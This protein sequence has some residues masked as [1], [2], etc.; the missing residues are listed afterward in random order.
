MK[1]DAILSDYDGTLCPTT[2][3]TLNNSLPEDLLNI[4][5][6][7]SQSIP[8]CIVSSKDFTFLE[9][10]S[11]F[12]VIICSIMGI[13]TFFLQKNK[14][15][16]NNSLV[17]YETISYPIDLKDKSKSNS[18]ARYR[19]K[20]KEKLIQ[21]SSILE[22]LSS[23]I[24]Q[25]FQDIKILKKYTHKE[26]LL[27][28]VS[29][30]YR[31]LLKWESYKINIEP[32][33]VDKISEYIKINLPQNNKLYIQEYLAHPFLD[34]YSIYCNK[35]DIVNEIRALLNLDRTKNILYLGDSEND[36]SAFRNAD[37]SINIK[38]DERLNTKLDS[39]Y[40]L[41]FNQLSYFLIKL[42]KENFNFT[43]MSM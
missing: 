30:D 12:A 5:C 14:K 37:L 4:L 1:I 16:F 8:V 11:N 6:D 19:I 31:H 3:L 33:I 24:S 23:I 7:I 35:G 21:N 26:K 18:L 15:D 22:D 36:N 2:S 42:H 9:S 40:S 27:A 43:S 34:I 39:Y 25:N 20:Q 32:R 17:N 28:G 13:E 10:C 41:E 29:F 38:S